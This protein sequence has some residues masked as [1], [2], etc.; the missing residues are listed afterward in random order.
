LIRRHRKD[1]SG[2]LKSPH[3]FDGSRENP[4]L[5]G[6]ESNRDDPYI[7]VPYDIDDCSV[8]IQ[9]RGSPHRTLS[10]LVADC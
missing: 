1:I 7:F 4:K 6:V 3:P 5:V 9:D 2:F 8:A 10:H